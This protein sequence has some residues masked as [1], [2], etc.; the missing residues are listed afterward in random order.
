MREK[1]IAF[2][3]VKVY[4]VGVY[5]EG[6][7]RASLKSWKGKSAAEL[8]TDDAVYKEL[9]EGFSSMLCSHLLMFLPKAIRHNV[10][11]VRP[12]CRCSRHFEFV[13]QINLVI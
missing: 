4:A 3:K 5:A 1:Q 9:A 10:P 11:Y 13:P 8:A 2:L 12:N 6:Q 7:V